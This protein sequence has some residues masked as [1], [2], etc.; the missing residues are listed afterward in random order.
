MLGAGRKAYLVPARGM[1][2]INGT[3]AQERDGVVVLDEPEIRITARGEAELVLAD[4][5]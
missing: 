5:P 4:L 2:E 1:L 3:T